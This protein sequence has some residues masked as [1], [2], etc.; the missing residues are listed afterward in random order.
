MKKSLA[1]RYEWDAFLYLLPAG[2]III[3]FHVIPILYSLVISFFDYSPFNAEGKRFIF[4]GVNNY[5]RLMQ[6]EEF[7]KSLLQTIYYAIGTVPLSIAVSLMVAMFLNSKIKG[8][9]LYRTIYFIP[10]ITSINAVSIVW[11]WLFDYQNGLLNYFLFT[12]G[13]EKLQWLESPYLAM[14]SIILMSIWKGLGY[15]VI[16]FLAGLQNIPK[17]L[18]E[19]GTIDGTSKWQSFRHI[20]WP[21]L[22][23]TTFF[24]LIMS[25]ISSFQ[26]F[27]Q[28]FM[29]TQG[30]PL[31]ST[32]VVVYYLYEQ[33]F[34]K[35]D[36]GYA[37][38]I[39]Y[40]L[41]LIIFSMTIFQRSMVGKKVHYS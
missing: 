35:I 6:D 16:I 12:L 2:L 39:A 22:S 29:M 34:Q 7:W 21:L 41:F 26:V 23:P 31:K 8:V 33:A 13:F 37:S 11:K 18:Y 38:A 17:T 19:A 32:T 14:P 24:I 9:S 25:T 28:V 27:A 10:V 5:I 4:T 30:G 15:N 1:K 40:A 20:T 3:T 36:L